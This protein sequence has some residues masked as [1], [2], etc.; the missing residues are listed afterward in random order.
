[1]R[2]QGSWVS[3]CWLIVLS[4]EGTKLRSFRKQLLLLIIVEYTPYTIICMYICIG[5]KGQRDTDVLT[6]VMGGEYLRLEW[7]ILIVQ[8]TYIYNFCGVKGGQQFHPTDLFVCRTR[9]YICSRLPWQ[10]FLLERGTCRVPDLW[11][12]ED[13]KR[14]PSGWN[15]SGSTFGF[16]LSTWSRSTARGL[17]SRLSW[18]EPAKTPTPRKCIS[19]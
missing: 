18:S 16:R 17:P 14:C 19:T 1:M 2:W 4:P 11:R 8:H 7:N 9:S 6:P 10:R 3:V 12:K 13:W 15:K 5:K